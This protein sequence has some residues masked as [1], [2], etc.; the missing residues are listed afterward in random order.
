MKQFL[1]EKLVRGNLTEFNPYS[2][3]RLLHACK[4]SNPTIE[5]LET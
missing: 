4:E 3:L 2:V 5:V 1:Q